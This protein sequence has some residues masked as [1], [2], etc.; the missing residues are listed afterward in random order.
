[1]VFIKIRYLRYSQIPVWDRT[2][3]RQDKNMK[4]NIKKKTCICLGLFCLCL[5]WL[6][7]C[8][9]KDSDNQTLERDVLKVGM[10]L[11]IE[12]LCYVSEET[13][14]PE[15]FDVELAQALAE[16]MDLEL[17]I[18]DTSQENLL[19]SLDGDLYDCVISGVGLSE[20]NETHYSH[21]ES[22][23]DAEAVKDQISMELTDTRL[24]VFTKKGSSLKDKLDQELEK[25][26]KDGTLTEI[27]QKY[28][29]ED[30]TG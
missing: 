6:T 22:Y 11:D 7:S 14:K 2:K 17:E 8:S 10:D 13:S 3:E 12:P 19:K 20:W 27:S 25:L 4:K 30:I 28:F 15:G 21:T 9:L 29:G 24:A 18:V 16:G 1:M 26:K 23:G 5:S